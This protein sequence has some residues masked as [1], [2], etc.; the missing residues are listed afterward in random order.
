MELTTK[1]GRSDGYWFFIWWWWVTIDL[2]IWS[3]KN[4]ENGLYG[5][6]S[7]WIYNQRNEQRL[8]SKSTVS[9]ESN[10]CLM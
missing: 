7:F 1:P 6:G 2:W 5:D 10:H 9:W 8:S 4:T 3:N